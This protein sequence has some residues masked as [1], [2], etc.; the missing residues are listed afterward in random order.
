MRVLLLVLLGWVAVA[1]A[2]DGQVRHL[3]LVG[4]STLMRR[5]EADPIGSWG[6][7]LGG[8]LVPGRSISNWALGG[9]T[10]VTIEPSWTNAVPSIARGDIVIFQ[11][12][13]NDAAPKKLVPEDRFKARLG[14]FV[15]IVRSH[16]AWPMICAPLSRVGYGREDDGKPFA[17][18]ADRRQYRDYA[19]ELAD[20][21]RV[22][23]V[24]MTALSEKWLAGL[25]RKEA[26][27]YCIGDT[28]ENGESWFDATH[29]TKLAAREY[30]RLFVDEVRRRGLPI[31]AWLE[32]F[33]R[34]GDK[35]CKGKTEARRL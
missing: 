26:L 13:I 19:R 24:D 22:D 14:E 21:K 29:P 27:G 33:P 35:Q 17:P 15:D 6:E 8:Y 28:T 16:G 11:F 1:G 20:A 5:T 4:D 2:D 23:F 9:K 3:H 12:G 10:V 7:A 32:G 30:A 31:A 25:S 18:S 34:G